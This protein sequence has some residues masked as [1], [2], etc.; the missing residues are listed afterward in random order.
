MELRISKQEEKM[1]FIFS[2]RI[3]RIPTGI[4]ATGCVKTVS[5]Y[6]GS[7]MRLMTVWNSR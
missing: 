3:S 5:M 4:F 1:N 7:E 6:S 2:H